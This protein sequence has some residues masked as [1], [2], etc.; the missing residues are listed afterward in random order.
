MKTANYQNT[1]HSLVNPHF[2][3]KA[4]DLEQFMKTRTDPSF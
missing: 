1:K 3:L 4:S 2:H